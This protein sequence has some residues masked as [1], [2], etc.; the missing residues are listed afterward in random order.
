[1]EEEKI[2]EDISTPVSDD[3]ISPVNENIADINVDDFKLPVTENIADIDKDTLNPSS[4]EIET[5]SVEDNDSEMG[6]YNKIEK[7]NMNL[8]E[9]AND[10]TV[11]ELMDNSNDDIVNEITM[12]EV[13]SEEV[14]KDLE[15]N[16]EIEKEI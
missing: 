9:L 8:D 4:V 15:S 11:D 12:P 5:P 1:M 13:S 6:I 10:L 7:L 3:I 14:S 16:E 2:V